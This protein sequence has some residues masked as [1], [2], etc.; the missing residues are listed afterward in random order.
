MLYAV[1]LT[2]HKCCGGGHPALL[3][4]GQ[5]LPIAICFATQQIGT[6]GADLAHTRP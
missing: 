4:A 1:C 5:A 6:G 2:I 3:K